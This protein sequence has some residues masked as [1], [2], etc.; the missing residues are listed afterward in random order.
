MRTLQ[1]ISAALL[2]AAAFHPINNGRAANQEYASCDDLLPA[3]RNI[4]GKTV[5]PESCLMQQA[6]V[7]YNEQRFVRVDMGLDGTAEGYVTDE[8]TYHEYLTNGP[9]L[10]FEQAAT[11]GERHLAIANYE[12]IRGAAILLV[13]PKDKA[14][15]NGKLWVTAHGRGRSFRNG[16]LRIWDRYYDPEAPMAAFDKI[17]KVMV[18]KGYALAVTR[19]TSEQGIGEVIATL[20]DGRVVDWAA[21]NDNS[22]IIKD[23]AAVAEAAIEKRLGRKPSRTY[24][25]GHSA[26]ARIARSLNYTPGLNSDLRGDPVFDGFLLDDS[27]TGLWLPV[28]MRD[29][30]DILFTKEEEREAF[31][32]QIELVHQM[33]TK[34]WDRAPNRPDW[35]TNAYLANKRINARILMDK[36][37]GSMF[38]IYEIRSMSH[39]GGEGLPPDNRRGKIHVLDV[40]LVIGGAIDMLDDLVEGR[41]EPVPSKSDWHDIGDIDGD[42]EIDHAAI[43]YPEVACPLGIFYPYPQSGAGTTAFAAFTGE[44]LEPLDKQNV[45]VDMNRNGVWDFRDTPTMAWRR[46]G[47][48]QPGEEL[49][50]E[51]YV[52]C[53]KDAAASL[54]EDGFFTERTASQYVRQAQSQNLD[55]AT[56]YE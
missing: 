50:S 4:A 27:A 7:V 5:G 51:R 35:V 56:L 37:L 1:I 41:G 34:V 16:A 17:D 54:R 2:L 49:T 26:G 21:F 31:R 24:L 10:I 23:Y 44:G 30:K 36:N 39:N 22:S 52:Q 12:R 28:V 42:G 15:W 43:A 14:K 55:P 20:D 53:I 40:S 38:R 19:R 13:Y 11:P 6:D 33:Y 46:L 8:G 45:F 29:G 48:L 32:P 9:D 47:L 25:Y 3:S 18:S